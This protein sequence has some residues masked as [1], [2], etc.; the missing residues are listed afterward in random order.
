V[1][2]APALSPLGERLRE[3]TAPLA[4]DD[5]AHGYAHAH[6]CEALAQALRQVAEIYDPP[7]P[8]PPG[9]PLID[10]ETCPDWALGWLAQVVGVS[11]P[12][13]ATPDQQRALIRDVSGWK[14][15]TP[16]ALRAIVA[17]TLTGS[18]TVYF[19]E[20][21]LGDAYALEVVTYTA[22]TPDPARSLAALR[23]QKPAG[24][25]LS[26]RVMATWDWEQV[27][28]D[29]ASWAAV[30]GRYDTWTELLLNAP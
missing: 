2:P 13:G 27:V 10:V 21:H 7:D 11:L 16:A 28:V 29:N 22:E 26:F 17:A 12:V 1:S 4:P 18:R 5:E 20:R 30:D 9:A 19:R 23:T 25:V 24:I 8:Y 3:R 15:G 6:L 14:R